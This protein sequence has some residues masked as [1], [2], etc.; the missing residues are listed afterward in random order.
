MGRVCVICNPNCLHAASTRYQYVIHY[1]NPL[2]KARKPM[3]AWNTCSDVSNSFSIARCTH[4][5]VL[6]AAGLGPWGLAG[7]ATSTGIY[8][9]G[10]SL[11]AANLTRDI[12]RP[13]PPS[14]RPGQPPGRLTPPGPALPG[15]PASPDTTQPGS[16]QGQGV[17]GQAGKPREG[18]ALPSQGQEQGLDPEQASGGE[19]VAGWALQLDPALVQGFG[20]LRWGACL[21]VLARRGAGAGWEPQQQMVRGTSPDWL[22]LRVRYRG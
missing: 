4:A 19:V 20:N 22:V 18:Q 15:R 17:E 11:S 14:G 2:A 5:T 16:G 12:I 13:R 21:A 1:P 7:N 8:N 6:Q 9:Y 3:L 10:S